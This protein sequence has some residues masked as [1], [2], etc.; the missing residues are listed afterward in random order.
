MTDRAP[1]LA[2][3]RS[4]AASVAEL[5]LVAWLFAVVM[6]G[7]AGFA[8]HQGRLAALQRDGVR[9]SE[10]VRTG[11]V[12]LGAELRHVTGGDMVLDADSARIRAFRGGGPICAG[13]G[14]A[15][16]V[17]YRGVRAPEPDKDSVLLMSV[18]GERA[19]ALLSA[20]RSPDC[21]GSV[22]LILAE[23]PA[24]P[25][26]LALIFETG[27][28]SLSGGAIRYRRGQGGRQPLTEALL[29]DM[30]FETGPGG[31]TVRLAPNLDSLPRLRPGSTSFPATTLNG[32]EVP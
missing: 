12:I 25:P 21:G 8:M 17:L 23:P 4:G 14:A 7:V 5:V 22:R 15:V 26:V 27:A 29:A 20:G 2:V 3:R 9:L 11:A 16:Y 30:A 1:W 6:A 31:A 24:A 19:A 10:A 32:R 13:D 18:A 28:Y